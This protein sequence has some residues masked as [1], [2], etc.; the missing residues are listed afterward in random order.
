MAC[1]FGHTWDGLVCKKCKK[2]K[3]VKEVYLPAE[4]EIIISLAEERIMFYQMLQQKDNATPYVII[5][6]IFKNDL[7]SEIT[8]NLLRAIYIMCGDFGVSKSF[9]GNEWTVVQNIGI[10][11][12]GE[13]LKSFD[14]DY[15]KFNDPFERRKLDMHPFEMLIAKQ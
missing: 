11:K 6:N 15:K 8:I 4:I 5:R 14:P 1:F 12:T 2:V 13:L 7:D 10:L 3:S 9:K